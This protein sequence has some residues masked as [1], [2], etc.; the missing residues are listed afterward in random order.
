MPTGQ[1]CHSQGKRAEGSLASSQELL[2][3]H[4]RAQKL[5]EERERMAAET[6]ARIAEINRRINLLAL[7][8][9]R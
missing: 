3:G 1:N 8:R 2:S 6:A 5:Q 9:S 4:R 7:Q